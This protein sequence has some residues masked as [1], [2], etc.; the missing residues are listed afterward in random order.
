M[1]LRRSS[2]DVSVDRASLRARPR[3]GLRATCWVDRCF[4]HDRLFIRCHRQCVTE[5]RVVSTPEGVG[6]VCHAPTSD[7]RQAPSIRAGGGG[8]GVT[9]VGWVCGLCSADDRQC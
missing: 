9:H 4:E 8:A 2:N 6:K 3:A 1:W 5:A 7:V